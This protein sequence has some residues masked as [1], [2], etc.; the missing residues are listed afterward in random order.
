MNLLCALGLAPSGPVG[1]QAAVHGVFSN[2]YA[3]DLVMAWRLRDPRP[4]P[5]AH[6]TYCSARVLLTNP[7]AF[8]IVGWSEAAGAGSQVSLFVCMDHGDT[9]R[10]QMCLWAGSAIDHAGALHALQGWHLDAMG[11]RGPTL[12]LPRGPLADWRV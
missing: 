6:Y 2:A 11:P 5:A 8:A 10:L 3:R 1:P 7:L 4:D 12:V 9:H